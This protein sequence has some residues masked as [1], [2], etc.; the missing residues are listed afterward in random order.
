M[1]NRTNLSSE[2]RWD[3]QDEGLDFVSQGLDT[4]KN[5]AEDMNQV[6]SVG[7]KCALLLFS[8]TCDPNSFPGCIWLPHVPLQE[9]D[10]QVPLMDEIDTKVAQHLLTLIPKEQ[11][12]MLN[13]CL[14]QC[15][16]LN[17]VHDFCAG[18]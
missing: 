11:K 7:R 10:R 5:L 14:P 1:K 3:V 9:L 13:F 12:K 18:G 2:F 8:V 6:S 4:L 16:R 17:D 15:L